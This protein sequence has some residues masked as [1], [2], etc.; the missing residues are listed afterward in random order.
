M[1]TALDIN[2]KDKIVFKEVEKRLRTQMLIK[3]L[4]EVWRTSVR[5]SHHF[6]TEED[7]LHLS[8][9]AE[10]GLQ[11]IQHLVVMEDAENPIGFMGVQ[12]KKIEMLYMLGTEYT[13]SKN[14]FNALLK[15]TVED[16]TPTYISTFTDGQRS[17]KL[18]FYLYAPI[19]ISKW[20]TMNFRPW[21]LAHTFP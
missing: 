15:S 18:Y 9:F 6:L 7:I 2:C 17:R 5:A 13:W 1:T 20:W 3:N 11:H 14:G 4:L 19:N 12:D 10:Q 21:G 8:P 16:G